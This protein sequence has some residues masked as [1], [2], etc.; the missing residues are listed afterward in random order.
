[1]VHLSIVF[2]FH[3]VASQIPVAL[4]Y[5]PLHA[6]CFMAGYDHHAPFSLD[7]M[8]LGRP[9][10]S[11]GMIGMCKMQAQPVGITSTVV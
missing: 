3:T 11:S 5:S 7:K 6:L 10:S 9:P 8:I 4:D 2:F 1:M